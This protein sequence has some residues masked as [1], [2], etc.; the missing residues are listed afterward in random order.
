MLKH[1][2]K[3]PTPQELYRIKKQRDEEEKEAYLPPGLVNHGNTCFMNSTLQGLIATPLLHELVYSGELQSR[4]NN[5]GGSSIL[6][7]R[8]PLLTNGHYVGGKYEREWVEGMPL[9]DRFIHTMQMAWRMQDDRKRENMSPRE[10]LTTIGTKYDQYLDFQQQDAHEFLRHLLDAMRMEEVDRQ[11][12]P[13]P[14]SKRRRKRKDPQSSSSNTAVASFPTT[15]E[16]SAEDKL[17][18]FVDML[19]GGRLA[20]ILVC[21]K[22]KKVSLTYEDFNDLSLSIKPEDY[23]KERK[24][25]KFKNLAKKLRFRP[26]DKD[27]SGV[28][29]HRSSSLPVSPVRRSADVTPQD[30][31]LPANEDRRRRSLDIADDSKSSEEAMGN[32]VEPAIQPPNVDAKA[33]PKAIDDEGASVEPDVERDPKSSPHVDFVEPDVKS[34]RKEDNKDKD[35][36]GK[37]G[38]R[39]SVSMKMGMSSKRNSRSKERKRTV[40][41]LKEGLASTEI[42]ST[43]TLVN[44]PYES[45]SE[46][47]DMS[48]VPRSRGISPSPGPSPLATPPLN[49]SPP[50]LVLQR[51][52]AEPSVHKHVKSPRPPKPTHEEAAYLRRLL[53]DVHPANSS[54]F[55]MFHQAISGASGSGSVPPISAHALLSKMG[56]L[57]GIDECLRMFTAVEI[58]D[59]DNMVGCHRCWKIANGTY[60]PRKQDIQKG[61]DEEE[62]SSEADSL[63]NLLLPESKDSAEES[64]ASSPDLAHPSATST[65][66]QISPSYTFLSDAESIASAPTTLQSSPPISNRMRPPPLPLGT[67]GQ[68]SSSTQSSPARVATYAGQPIPSISTT[69]PESPLTQTAFN[70][71]EDDAAESLGAR[72]ADAMPSNDSL[73]T[74]KVKRTPQQKFIKALSGMFDDSDSSDEADFDDSASDRSGSVSAYSDASSLASRPASPA[75][76]PR[77][78]VEKLPLPASTAQS[79]RSDVSRARSRESEEKRKK[80]IPRSQQ[81][82]M[83]RTYKR[84]LIADPPPILVIH[85]KR[86]QQTPKQYTVSFTGG[87]KKLDDFVAFPE[88]LDLAPYLAPKKEDFGLKNSKEKGMK[89]HLDGKNEER[90]MYRL[91]AV[92]VHI[93]NMLGGHYVAYTALPSRPAPENSSAPSSPKPDADTPTASNTSDTSK[94]EKDVVGSTKQP[95]QWAYISDTIVRLTTIEE[96][97]KAKAYICMYERI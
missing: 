45:S 29:M 82:L 5:P 96:V 33:P 32:V 10:I 40:D 22:C 20:S 77:A 23:V 91:Y 79:S 14:K 86:F 24:R 56:H 72:L 49:I 93:G 81:V 25:D 7:R 97:L 52:S 46:L 21:E 54:P 92:V 39:I 61:P 70:R 74:P 9:G 71:L 11:P 38:R 26:A 48:D 34:T 58:L 60:K 68:P 43:P 30:S 88:Y 28:P 63:E 50:I 35:A 78:S 94:S 37:L 31:E 1:R 65:P 87:F 19:F 42:S 53:A 41:I 67:E 95:R 76:S 62:D 73:L 36:W 66:I 89:K 3:K 15:S 83:R 2:D 16:P 55:A 8:S 84:Y 59:S 44:S 80:R 57:P 18:S 85:L 13:P 51:D 64:T 90:C 12:P 17:Q 27:L 4:W 47:G 75:G 69:A 6:S